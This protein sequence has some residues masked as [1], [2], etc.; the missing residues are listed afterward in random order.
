MLPPEIY[1][2]PVLP[3]ELEI[4]A[5]A[6]FDLF[7]DR[8]LSMGGVGGIHW[9]S[10]HQYVQTLNVDDDTA[11]FISRGVRAA[12]NLFIKY[13]ADKQKKIPPPPPPPMKTPRP[14]AMRR[15]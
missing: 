7:H 15:H 8:S 14:S 5:V 13:V 1:D 9:S 3:P 11:E 6:F 12:D 10:L 2:A 4:I